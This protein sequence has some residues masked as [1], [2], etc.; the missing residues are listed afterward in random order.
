MILISVGS[1][2]IHI[3]D[4]LRFLVVCLTIHISLSSLG[5]SVSLTIHISLSLGSDGI[6][7]ISTCLALAWLPTCFTLLYILRSLSF[8]YCFH[9]VPSRLMG[10][11]G[12]DT[13]SLS[14]D[15]L[16]NSAPE[17]AITLFEPAL[18]HCLR[19][20]LANCSHCLIS[21]ALAASVASLLY[22]TCTSII[23][24]R[25]ISRGHSLCFCLCCSLLL[26]SCLSLLL[27]T[28]VSLLR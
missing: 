12:A 14:V 3:S 8:Q 5:F 24:L 1:L 10:L 20:V 2:T 9:S 21:I 27:Y 11:S 26:L 17:A 28:S 25:S 4:S 18:C 6:F 23:R 19:V 13:Y 22:S 16:G 15:F 7:L